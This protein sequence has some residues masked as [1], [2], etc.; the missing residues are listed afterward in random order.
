M[1]SQEISTDSVIADEKKIKRKKKLRFAAIVFVLWLA[2]GL[3]LG[4]FSDGSSAELHIEIMAPRVDLWGISVSTSVIY[5]VISTLC[6][7]LA[8]LVFRFAIFPRFT[9][10]P[11][12]VQSVIEIMVDTI[13]SY[14]DTQSGHLGD[15]L[16]A[17]IFSLASLMIFS[18]V[19]ELLGQRPP[20]ADLVMTGSMALCTFFLINFYG[21][22]KKGLG[23]RIGS[24][25]QPVAIVFP[26]RILSDIAIPVSLACRLFGNML[27]GMIIVHLLYM[28]LGSFS[29]G[30]PAVTGLYFNVFHPLIQ[31]FIFVTLSLTFIREAVE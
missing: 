28:A 19:F 4:Q 22:K 13:Q 10:E 7:G 12:G 29:I 20:T 14:T 24:F 30:I 27:G 26:I 2:A 23:G 25:A 1:S 5:A 31:A 9:N 21:V 18:E 17:Y 3:I 15:N 6:L 16:G 11:K 8:G